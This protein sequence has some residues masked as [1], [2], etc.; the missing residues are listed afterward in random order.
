MEV[1][2]AFEFWLC[3]RDC[4]LCRDFRPDRSIILCFIL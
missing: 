4:W 1:L 2:F 3:S